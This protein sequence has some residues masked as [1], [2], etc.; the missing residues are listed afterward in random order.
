MGYWSE[1]GVYL[2]GRGEPTVA[3][4]I[5]TPT[6]KGEGPTGK[7]RLRGNTTGTRKEK[8]EDPEAVG[9]FIGDDGGVCRLMRWSKS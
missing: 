2:I 8:R 4:E 1:K 6:K 3:A 5:R 9:E 7:K